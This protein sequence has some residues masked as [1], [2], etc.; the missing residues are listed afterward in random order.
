MT[1]PVRVRV[2]RVNVARFWLV[3]WTPE[4]PFS[5]GGAATRRG[6]QGSLTEPYFHR[7]WVWQSNVEGLTGSRSQSS[8]ERILRRI[9]PV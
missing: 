9:R 5:R 7:R 3:R 8:K 4:R 6:S 1:V 2:T